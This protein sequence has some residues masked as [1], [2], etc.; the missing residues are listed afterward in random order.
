MDYSPQSIS[1]AAIT[2]GQAPPGATFTTAS[3]GGGSSHV[4]QL[5]FSGP[6]GTRRTFG[7]ATVRRS[8]SARS[9]GGNSSSRRRSSPDEISLGSS[10]SDDDI[11]FPGFPSG[12]LNR[13]TPL[14][15]GSFTVTNSA[16]FGPPRVARN[17]A[18]NG[19]DQ[20]AGNRAENPLT[21][22]DSSD[23][24][25]DDGILAVSTAAS[26]RQS[27]AARPRRNSNTSPAAAAS[28]RRR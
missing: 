19:S 12:I 25:D 16:L 26:H 6:S 15:S 27:A 21:I 24:D 20:T 23:D 3:L 17:Y 2:G 1:T 13:L 5:I 28:R 14:A 9:A 4:A 8:S 22:D 7:L 10:S 18:S 11:A